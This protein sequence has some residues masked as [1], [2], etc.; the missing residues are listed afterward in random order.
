MLLTVVVVAYNSA[1]AIEQTLASLLDAVSELDS[2]IILI[3]NASSDGTV[4]LAERTLGDQGRVI[5]MTEDLGFGAGVN[6]GARRARGKYLLMMNDDVI[7]APGNIDR[8]ITTLQEH[9]TVAMVGPVLCHPD[10]SPTHSMHRWT[11]GWRDEISKA[12]DRAL[13]TAVRTTI[14]MGVEVVEVGVLFAACA[15]IETEFFLQIG[16]FNDAFFIYGQDLDLSRRITSLGRAVALDTR[17]FAIHYQDEEL[18]RRPKGR[19]FSERLM[20][21][22]DI[23]YRI[24]LSRPSQVLLHLWHTIGRDNQPFRAIYHVKRAFRLGPSLRRLRRPS[25]LNRIEE[26]S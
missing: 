19:E 20:D 14:P 26:G 3:D 25:P 18:A 10:G 1:S 24:W 5:Q 8:L 4:A 9:Q 23:Y 6:E 2:E 7:V 12:R 22:R 13:G 15:V 21:A 16:G 11:P 17:A